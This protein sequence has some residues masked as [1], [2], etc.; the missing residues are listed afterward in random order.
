VQGERALA[1]DNKE[2]G[3]FRL[4]GIPPAPRGVPQIEVLFDIDA[5]GIVQVSAK[6]T[7]T[8]KEQKITITASS[9]LSDADIDRAV[10]EAEQYAEA[11]RIRRE[12]IDAKNEADSLIFQTEKLLAD[13][14]DKVSDEDKAN[15]NAE[16]EKLKSVSVSMHGETM[17][18]SDTETLKN[19]TQNYAKILNEFSQK[20]YQNAQNNP[21]TEEPSDY[22]PNHDSSVVD[23]DFKEV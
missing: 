14:G 9:N 20:L 2:L 17:N 5:N 7:G 10:K 16:A 6:D 13:V 1:R 19:A 15:L 12:A 18:E 11:D 4:D 23:G 8:G 3:R 21:K 22:G